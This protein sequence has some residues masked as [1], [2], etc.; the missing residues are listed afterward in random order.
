MVQ[1]GKT[2]DFI[3]RKGEHM[4][5]LSFFVVEIRPD[6][7]RLRV[8]IKSNTVYKKMVKELLDIACA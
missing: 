5:L 2:E 3:L 6:G 1:Y 4:N 7:S 8:V